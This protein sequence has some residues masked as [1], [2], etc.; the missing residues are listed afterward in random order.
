MFDVTKSYSS[1]N[2]R[3]IVLGHINLAVCC[4]CPSDVSHPQIQG[5]KVMYLTQTNKH[6]NE[7]VGCVC[8]KERHQSSQRCCR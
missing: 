8:M 2:K 6:M 3:Q 7:L 5:Q 1:E 4:F